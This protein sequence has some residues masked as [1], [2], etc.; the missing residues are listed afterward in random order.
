L[1]AANVKQEP[2]QCLAAIYD[3]LMRHVDYGSWA[4]YLSDL[5]ERFASRP[6]S[7]ADLACGTGNISLD[8]CALGRPVVVGVDISEAMLRVA[9]DKAARAGRQIDFVPGD[10]RALEGLAGARS[11]DAAV[12]IYDSFNYLLTR[13]E[14]DRALCQVY[15]L[16]QPDSLFIFDICTERN[17]QRYFKDFREREEGPGFTYERH[18]YFDERE[19]LQLN[20]FVVRFA[21]QEPTYEE[22][23]TQRIYPVAELAA[24]LDAS[25]FE[26]LGAFDGFTFRPGSEKSDRIHFVLRRPRTTAR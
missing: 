14:V 13:Q 5:L 26:R 23:H 18:S 3:Y 9:R 11:F 2:Y 10:L 19:R 21:G 12:C 1:A 4:A 7:L 17:S 8:L 24:A 20:H 22:L 15:D 6:R 16:L 25:P